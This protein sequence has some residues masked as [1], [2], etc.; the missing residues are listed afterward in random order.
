MSLFNQTEELAS[1]DAAEPTLE[2]ITY[3]RWKTSGACEVKLDGIPLESITNVM[4][5]MPYRF[6]L[7]SVS[8]MAY[9]LS[10]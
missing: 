2:T 5:P 1:P 10:Q 3:H 9:I 4:A 7:A 8:V 6:S